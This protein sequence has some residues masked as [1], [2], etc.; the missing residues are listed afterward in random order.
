MTIQARTDNT[1]EPLVLSD[2][3]EVI[4]GI[5]IEAAQGALTAGAVLGEVT[6]D[7]GVYA[8]VDHT[9]VDGTQLPKL[10]LSADLANDAAQQ[11]GIS[12]YRLGMFAA[13]KLT[14]GGTTTLD[15][16]LVIQTNIDLTMRDALRM[17]GMRT[18]TTLS[19]TGFENA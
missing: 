16:R 19:L 17:F 7:P 5:T 6:A 9:A 11:T 18:A 3:A 2:D 15:S 14:F 4:D 13:E 8:L 10:I 1:N 12:A